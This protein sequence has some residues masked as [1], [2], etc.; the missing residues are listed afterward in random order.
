VLM[1]AGG[2][3]TQNQQCQSLHKKFFCVVKDILLLRLKTLAGSKSK[4]KKLSFW[5]NI[6]CVLQY[7]QKNVF[8][9]VRQHSHICSQIVCMKFVQNEFTP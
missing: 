2:T 6:C 8:A 7:G 9:A 1:S 4:F 5:Q 3:H